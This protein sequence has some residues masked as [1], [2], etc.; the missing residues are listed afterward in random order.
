SDTSDKRNLG[1]LLA[2]AIGWDRIAF[3]DDDI[4]I[5]NPEDLQDAAR[6]LDYYA[7]VSLAV[8]GYP[9]NSVVC[10][11]HRATG[12]FQETFI[13]GAALVVGRELML[14]FFPKIY[15]EDWF[16]LLDDNQ[17][18]S[19]AVTGSAFQTPYDPY[20]HDWRARSEEFG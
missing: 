1:L 4:M 2:R 20:I 14:S 3:F 13:G 8:G 12:G 15:N 10:L 16:F 5:P 18:K 6:L 17:L 11:A 9:D 7:A 19:V